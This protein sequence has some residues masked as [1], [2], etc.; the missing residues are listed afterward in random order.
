VYL[1]ASPDFVL[2]ADIQQQ[3]N[4][5]LV[6]RFDAEGISFARPTQVVEVKGTKSSAF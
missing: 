5:E 3:I 2:S 1:I 6:R 4:L